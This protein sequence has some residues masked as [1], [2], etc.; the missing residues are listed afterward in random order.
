MHALDQLL[1]PLL[2]FLTDSLHRGNKKIAEQS[3]LLI[4][5]GCDNSSLMSNE[6]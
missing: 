4:G 1:E 2:E 5:G 3:L 6:I